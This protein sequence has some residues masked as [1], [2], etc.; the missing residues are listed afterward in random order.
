MPQPKT[1]EVTC[2]R[3]GIVLTYTVGTRRGFLSFAQ[4][5]VGMHGC[6]HFAVNANREIEQFDVIEDL[7]AQKKDVTPPPPPPEATARTARS[8]RA[9]R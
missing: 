6:D 3:D 8:E 2:P 4:L 5:H 1:F 7:L 9:E